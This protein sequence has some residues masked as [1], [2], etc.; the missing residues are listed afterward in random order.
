MCRDNYSQRTMK[1]NTL[2]PKRIFRLL[3]NVVSA[4]RKQALVHPPSSS[5]PIGDQAFDDRYRKLPDIIRSWTA[6]WM[7]LESSD[8]L[9]FGCGEGITALGMARRFNAQSV[10][11]VDIMPDPSQC[12][13]RAEEVLG[14]TELPG[15]L[16]LKQIRPGEMLG[17]R[18]NFD[19]IYSWSV[20]EH[21]SQPLIG[22]I[23]RQLRTLLR[24][25]GCLFIQI[26]PLYYSS[27][28][29]H[30]C[31]KIPEP[32][33]HLLNQDDLYYE[34]LS[35][36]C[37]KDELTTLW[38]TFQTL[39][40]LTVYELKKHL[41]DAGFKVVREHKTQDPNAANIPSPLLKIFREEILLVDQI[42]FL[43]R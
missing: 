28:G 26:A 23:L 4:T 39:N 33:G 1:N 2:N 43:C 9:D 10:L 30:L 35:A 5:C 42:V 19:L 12:L 13:R 36:A 25:G 6:D 18:A 11:G 27:E 16:S 3:R 21:V 37:S 41:A 7:K 14:L 17:E 22:K 24:P 31:H 32:W 20:F 38:S 15:N 8:V 40:K 29:S 34:K